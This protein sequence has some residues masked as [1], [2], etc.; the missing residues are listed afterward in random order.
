MNISIISSK[1]RRNFIK[2]SL[3]SG[4]ALFLIPQK[5]KAWWPLIVFIGRIIATSAVRKV[6]QNVVRSSVV[7]GLTSNASKNILKTSVIAAAV[8]NEASASAANF[9]EEQ[10]NNLHKNDINKIANHLNCPKD[11]YQAIWLR[12]EESKSNQLEIPLRNANNST[13]L[14]I[15]VKLCLIDENSV[16]EQ[17]QT[18]NLKSKKY[19]DTVHTLHFDLSELKTTGPKKIVFVSDDMTSIEHIATNII[20][21]DFSTIEKLPL[22]S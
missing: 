22:W 4:T 11:N 6:A 19:T 9:T 5:S 8:V 16:V 7:R 20:V 12:D 1:E 3:I 15:Y 18:I 14:D 2:Y 21:S 10:I 13:D 17:S